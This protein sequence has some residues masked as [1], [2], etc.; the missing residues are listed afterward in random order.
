MALTTTTLA[1]AVAA[2]DTQITV[3]ASTGFVANQIVKIDQEFM[4]IGAAYTAAVNGVNVP[5]RRGQNGTVAQA[6]PITANVIT[7]A[8]T[9][10]AGPLPTVTAGYPLSARARVVT[11]YTA[12]GAITLPTPGSDSVAVLNGT[13]ALAMTLAAPTA[14]MDGCILTVIGNGKAAHTVTAAGGFGL[15]STGYTVGTFDTNAQCSI[16]L[17]ACGVAWVFLG[18]PLSGTLTGVDVAIA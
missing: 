3:A 7:G 6:H 8:G 14:D 13:Q 18:S 15:G 16:Q 10:F 11:S 12:D 5:V 2:N 4:A 9:D 1:A 17:M